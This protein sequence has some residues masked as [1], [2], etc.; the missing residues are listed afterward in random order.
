MILALGTLS[1]PF[2]WISKIDNELLLIHHSFFFLSKFFFH[3]FKP[4]DVELDFCGGRINFFNLFLDNLHG[5]Q[6]LINLRTLK[7]LNHDLINP[8]LRIN[9][10]S[11]F[12][13]SLFEQSNS[14]ITLLEQIYFNLHF[15]Y[16]LEFFDFGKG[17]V[18]NLLFYQD[19][20]ADLAQVDGQGLEDFGARVNAL[21]EVIELINLLERYYLNF[22]HLFWD[23]IWVF[24]ER[25]VVKFLNLLIAVQKLILQV[26]YI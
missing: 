6:L 3:R 13:V 22:F 7:L 8:L 4:F 11:Q 17:L 12:Q 14:I 18:S 23:N 20:F 26:T 9:L 24:L 15:V 16:F 19:F 2:N 25:I 1:V 5:L 10:L 21:V